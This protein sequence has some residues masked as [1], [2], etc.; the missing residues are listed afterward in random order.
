MEPLEEPE[1]SEKVDATHCGTALHRSIVDNNE[2]NNYDNNDDN[3]DA[4]DDNNKDNNEDNK[5]DNITDSSCHFGIAQLTLI[6]SC[7]S[8]LD[9]Y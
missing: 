3:N 8:C 4:N 9:R 5:N 1:D 2:D 6:L 7:R